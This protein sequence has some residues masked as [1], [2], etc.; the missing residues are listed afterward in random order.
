MFRS[1]WFLPSC[2]NH[3]RIYLKILMLIPMLG[4]SPQATLRALA[5]AVP[6]SPSA[7]TSAEPQGANPAVAVKP[8]DVVLAVGD[9]KMTA[10]EF[11]ALTSNLP[12]EVANALPSLGKKGFA[13]RYANL[14]GLAKEGEKLK[15]DQSEIFLRLMSFQRMMLLA[16]LTVNELV[17]TM[18][19]VSA[20]EISSYYTA[21]QSDFQQAKVRGIYIPFSA[22]EQSEKA[23][24]PGDPKSKQ[25]PLSEAQARAK[26]EALR[27]RIRAGEDM[28]TLAKKESEHP[29][30]P[31]GGD[32]GF[33]RRNQLSPQ[34]DKVIFSLEPK[35]VS[36]P[37]RDRFGYFI[38]Q[39]E[40]KRAQPLEDA[41][42]VIENELRQQKLGGA[43]GKV[44]A[45][46]PAK[47]NPDYFNEP[48]PA[49]PSMPAPPGK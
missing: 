46:Y 21:H 13:E 48:A 37:V 36:S 26:A 34:I 4:F 5:Q 2:K 40:E 43:L 32:F 35:Q 42:G 18:G 3:F 16:Q 23:A 25:A 6:G 12:P 30:A 9:V 39:V 29:T 28:A 10:K 24:A 7:Q 11:E 15:V 33:V 17:S 38:L 41:R 49:F 44:Q 45:E 8:D 27:D 20:A 1:H 47:L 22:E 19:E 31:K 14:L